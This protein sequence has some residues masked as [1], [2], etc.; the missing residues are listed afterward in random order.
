MEKELTQGLFRMSAILYARN[1]S[2]N[3]SIKQIIRKIVEDALFQNAADKAV[4]LSELVGYINRNYAITLSDDEVTSIIKDQKFE[5]CFDYY[6]DEGL[7]VSLKHKRRVMIQKESADNKNLGDYVVAFVNNQHLDNSKIDVLYRFLYGVF[8]T[9]LEGYKQLLKE[10]N[11]LK[12]DD[13]LFEDEDK[14]LI[15]RFL[16]WDDKGKNAAVFNLASYALEYCMLT[17]KKD[18]LFELDNLKNKNLYF[19]SNILFR[20]I[21]VNG[22]D[23]RLRA[24]QFL[25]K[26]SKVRQNLFITKETDTEIRE[27]IDYYITKLNR[28]TTPTAKVNPKVYVETVDIDGFYKLYFKWRINRSDGSIG[29]FKVHLLA[30]YDEILSRFNIQK[31]SI[32]PYK[33]DDVEEQLKDYES[34]ILNNNDDKSYSAASFDARN[35]MWMEY[36][37]NG[38]NDDIYRVKYFFVSSDQHLRRWDFNRNTNEVPIV[39]LPSQWLSMV[40]RYME[41]S[42]DDYKS[43]VCFLNMKV[44]KPSLSEEQLLYA[45]EGISEITSD[46]TQQSCLIKSFI[47]EDFNNEL[48]GLSNEDLQSKAKEYAE[49]EYDKRIKE[50]ESDSQCH[51]QRIEDLEND[52]LKKERRINNLERANKR[53][54]KQ[55]QERIH[56]LQ[57]KLANVGSELERRD[58]YYKIKD[59]NDKLRLRRW[60]TPRC[61]VLGALL[62]LWAALLILCF[63]ATDWEYNYCSRVLKWI[64][65]LDENRKD[66]AKQ[67]IFWVYILL[68]ICLAYGFVNILIVKSEDKKREWYKKIIQV[69]KNKIES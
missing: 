3:I 51:K 2:S 34:Q 40:L 32:K 57:E 52:S 17:N 41:R 27:T 8:T 59:E 6:E 45:I 64:A 54:S 30:K 63:V 21:G 4:L 12:V 42:D 7:K 68:G 56:D 38:Q 28:S 44:N 16:D 23:R 60:K 20:A 46:I 49:T 14:L 36:K 11:L 25:S 19:D 67:I 24:E 58:D 18:A 69:I 31:D 5:D 55:S 62:L 39:M 53:R 61:I 66:I 48:Q 50:L 26:F 33:E 37:R 10:R 22:E 47:K 43:F 1:N 35:I 65:E 13:S 29:A 15:N 9:N